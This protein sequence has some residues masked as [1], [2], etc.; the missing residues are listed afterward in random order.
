MGVTALK[1]AMNTDRATA[2][3]FFDNFKNT[4][5][6]LMEYLEEVKAYAKTHGNVLTL[7]GRKRDVPMI[8]SHI[9]FIK[10]QG[11]RIAINAPIQGTSAE[12]LK[13]GM[14]DVYEKYSKEMES[15]ELKLLLQIHDELV[16]EVKKGDEDKYIDEIIKLMENVLHK[17]KL[18]DLPLKV[19]SSTGL[20]LYEL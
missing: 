14:I 16:F 13:L 9:P 15:G 7:L 10:A 11:E 4:F 6:R 18:S 5:T 20:T 2:Q 12:V 19:S 1:D 3:E 17:R 8:K